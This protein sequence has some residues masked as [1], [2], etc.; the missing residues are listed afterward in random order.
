MFGSF[1]DYVF[2][3]TYRRD[4]EDSQDTLGANNRPAS[5]NFSRG[6]RRGGKEVGRRQ[7]EN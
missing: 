4:D 7:Y 5:G 1:R 2:L 3:F 6:R